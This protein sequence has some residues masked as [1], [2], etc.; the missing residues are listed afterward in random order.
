LCFALSW[1]CGKIIYLIDLSN[2]VLAIRFRQ[3]SDLIP[4]YR[5]E[6]IYLCFT[7][8]QFFSEAQVPP[9][10]PQEE[11]PRACSSSELDA[12]QLPPENSALRSNNI[13]IPSPATASTTNTIAANITFIMVFI[14]Y[15]KYLGGLLTSGAIIFAGLQSFF[16]TA[17]LFV[18]YAFHTHPGHVGIMTNPVGREF[19]LFFDEY[20]QGQAQHGKAEQENRYQKYIPKHLNNPPFMLSK[21]CKFLL[22]K[23]N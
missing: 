2:H 20:I 12:W 11:I 10:Q 1:D 4:R 6:R 18:F 15:N 5:S 9:P 19:A 3:T 13:L 23:D 14:C 7:G 22:C 8:D 21:V 17:D 16:M